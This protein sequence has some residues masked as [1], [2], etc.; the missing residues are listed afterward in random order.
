MPY[1]T[2]GQLAK[3][4]QV[5]RETIRYYERRG[6]LP[7]PSRRDSGYRQYSQEDVAR[8]RF[9]KR[10]QEL[11]FSLKE[12]LELLSLRVGPET[13]CDDVKRRAESKIAA[14]EEKIRTLQ[15]MR[16]TLT[17]LVTAC[18]SRR[19]TSECPILETLHIGIAFQ[20]IPMQK[21]T[22]E[23]MAKTLAERL[24]PNP[25]RLLLSQQLLRLLANGQPVSPGQLA[26]ALHMPYDQITVFLQ[27]SPS[28]EY[29]DAGNI[30]GAGLSLVPTSHRFQVNGHDLFTWCAMDTLLYPVVL[31]QTAQVESR[32]PVSRERIRLTVT[33]ERIEHLEPASAMVSVVI[34]EETCCNIRSTFCNHVHF[35][36]SS[37]AATTWLATHTGLLMLPVT[38]A[39]Q[40]GHLL[41]QYRLQKVAESMTEA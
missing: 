13:A 28:I 3:N 27:Q 17:K 10:A 39:Y 2:I 29:D 11:G 24:N 21:L 40:V 22:V 14:I 8:I 31:Q 9:I 18:N 12:I 5:H 37:D 1:F 16:E 33:P 4:A 30:I 26:K 25:V 38:E 6:L 41:L 23:E 7:P 35:F 15:R 19:P 32:C 20:E 34:P 36:S